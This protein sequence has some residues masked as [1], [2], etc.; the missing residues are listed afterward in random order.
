MAH[1]SRFI[2]RWLDIFWRFLGTPLFW[3]ICLVIFTVQAV[4]IALMGS[5][6]MAFDEHFHLAAIQ[7]YAKVIFPWQVAQP[8]G[9]ATLSAFTA[10]GS[11]L[12]HF[13]MSWPYRLLHLFI[14]SQTAIIVLFRLFD[15]AIVVLGLCIFRK[16]LRTLQLSRAAAH[17]IMAIIITMPMTPFMAGQLTY[18][19][20]FFTLS[21]ATF[22]ALTRVVQELQAHS[23]V[24]LKSM[25]WAVSGLLFTSQV[26]YAFLPVALGAG[27][28]MSGYA[29]WLLR[30]KRLRWPKMFQE[31]RRQLRGGPALVALGVMLLGGVLFVQRY[32]QNYVQYGSLVPECQ[33]VLGHER[34]L[35]FAPYFR[36]ADIREKGWYTSISPESKLQYP[37]TWLNKMIYESYFT[38]GPREGN[39]RS[40]P[41]LPVS[42]AVGYVLVFGSLLVLLVGLVILLRAGP[43]VGLTLSMTVVYMAVLYAVNYK[44]F[45]NTAVPLSIHGRYALIVLPLL[46]FLVY[47]VLK[48]MRS[49]QIY[50]Y[51]IKAFV[52]LLLMGAL[53][54]GGILVFIIRSDDSWYWP[55]AVEFSRVVRSMFWPFIWR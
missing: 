52:V 32:G 51:T 18:D 10:D 50:T 48:N 11:Y 33:V 53:W 4:Y 9:P 30:G 29:A 1:Y 27:L 16:V 45:L 20:L 42:F 46:G 23:K 37:W 35:G 24:A 49:S 15:V 41:P 19:S 12:Y 28:F 54:N 21:A 38:V 7:E 13:L 14:D 17:S 34:C 36:D 25:A 43:M 2:R 47:T 3:R 55:H 8:P 5:F 6:S 31:W 26:K 22:L 44:A 39:Y 40:A